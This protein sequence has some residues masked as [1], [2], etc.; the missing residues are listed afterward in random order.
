MRFFSHNGAQR[1]QHQTKKKLNSETSSPNLD[2]IKRT[3]LWIQV[4][5]AKDEK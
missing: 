3:N 1:P 4:E 5:N 2:S